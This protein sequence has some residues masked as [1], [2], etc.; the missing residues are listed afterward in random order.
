MVANNVAESIRILLDQNICRSYRNAAYSPV[1]HSYQI[2]K[3]YH[4][5]TT[6]NNDITY[7]HPKYIKYNLKS[8]LRKNRHSF[9]L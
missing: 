7:N 8:D 4:E 2:P 6:Y 1:N 5:Y 3:I 9:I